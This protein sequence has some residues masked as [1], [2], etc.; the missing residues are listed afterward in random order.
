MDYKFENE[1]V[2]RY[3]MYLTLKVIDK[4][5]KIVI[6]E[7]NWFIQDEDRLLAYIRYNKAQIFKQNKI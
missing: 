1:I 5:N 2:G 7:S 6:S 3:N 4:N